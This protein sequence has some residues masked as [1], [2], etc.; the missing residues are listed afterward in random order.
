MLYVQWSRCNMEIVLHGEPMARISLFTCP[1]SARQ[2]PKLRNRESPRSRTSP[3][4]LFPNSLS[5]TTLHT[6]RHTTL[7]A[8]T[9]TWPPSSTPEYTYI[10]FMGSAIPSA[11]ALL[12]SAAQLTLVGS[13]YPYSP[14]TAG[15]NKT[16]ASF[17]SLVRQVGDGGPP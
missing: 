5:N 2:G 8:R 12:F 16:D 7:A 10:T 4:G 13:A 15:L 17:A 3:A 11:T 6:T 1:R 14:S 9:H